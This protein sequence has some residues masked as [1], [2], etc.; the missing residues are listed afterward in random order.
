MNARFRL[1]NFE[2]RP[3]GGMKIPIGAVIERAGRVAVV[4]ASRLPDVRSFD[5]QAVAHA[6]DYNVALLNSIRAFDELPPAFSP[7]AHWDEP[8][9]TPAG[10]DDPV[11]WV[12]KYILP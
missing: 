3:V 10:V 1:L 5:S 4:R 2:T 8:R 9:E 11:A 12:T 7:Q 6:L